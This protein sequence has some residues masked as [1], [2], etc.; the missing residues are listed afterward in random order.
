M[1]EEADQLR[2][3]FAVKSEEEKEKCE[4]EKTQLR[5]GCES[6]IQ[7]MGNVMLEHNKVMLEGQKLLGSQGNLLRFEEEK[8][9]TGAPTPTSVASSSTLSPLL[10]IAP[11]TNLT[12][13][14]HPSPE[15]DCLPPDWFECHN[16]RC[17]VAAWKCDKENDCMDWSD[18]DYILCKTNS[19]NIG[20]VVQNPCAEDEFRCVKGDS[21]IPAGWVCDRQKDCP[22]GEDEVEEECKGR[23]G[24]CVPNT[25][26]RC[27]S[28]E[29]ISSSWKCDGN[30]DCED[31]SDEAADLCSP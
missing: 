23:L 5:V 20:T 3:D 14:S 28:G 16:K 27:S 21:C 31:G 7:Y 29:C 4:E 1:T 22:N 13:H 15:E 19:S 9:K 10:S 30:F 25:Q 18:E 6:T 12:D 2:E 8:T 24:S 26:F 17:I 11:T